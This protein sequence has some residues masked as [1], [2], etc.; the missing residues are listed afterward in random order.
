M[1]PTAHSTTND[2]QKHHFTQTNSSTPCANGWWRAHADTPPHAGYS[3]TPGQNNTAHHYHH[4]RS[5]TTRGKQFFFS[6]SDHDHHD[7]H[8]Y[9]P[10]HDH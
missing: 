8:D 10:D 5:H 7:Y 1:P 3:P 2:E 4:S 9:D 6:Y